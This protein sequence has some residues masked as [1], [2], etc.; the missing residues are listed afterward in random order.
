MNNEDLILKH[1]GYACHFALHTANRLCVH[2][3]SDD[4]KGEA[5][6]AL[7]RSGIKFDPERGLP[8]AGVVKFRIR[9]ALSDYLRATE[10]AFTDPLKD[11]HSFEC[12]FVEQNSRAV[13]LVRAALL[14]VAERERNILI[15]RH[16]HG[17][18]HDKIGVR[19]GVSYGRVWQ[20]ENRGKEQFRRALA[21]R[22]IHKVADIL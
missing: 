8:F 21:R 16:C 19:M 22:G 6:L 17:L 14:E 15:L 1:I 3:E 20:L 11:V 18:S 13:V 10:P 5:L 4:L 7:V 2:V 12:E 9:G